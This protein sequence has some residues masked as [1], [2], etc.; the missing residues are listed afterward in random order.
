M[1]GQ[2]EYLDPKGALL[3][4]QGKL[5]TIGLTFDIPAMSEDSELRRCLNTIWWY[6]SVRV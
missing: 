5:A 6:H 3:Q 2:R 4:L 1:I